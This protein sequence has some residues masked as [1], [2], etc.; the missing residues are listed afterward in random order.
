MQLPSK[1]SSRGAIK[2]NLE[3]N[4]LLSIENTSEN[5]ELIKNLEQNLQIND[6]ILIKHLSAPVALVQVV[7][8]LEQIQFANIYQRKVKVLDWATATMG[9]YPLG[10]NTPKISL[11]SP[12]QSKYIKTWHEQGKQ[13]LINGI[14]LRKLHISQQKMFKNF[15]ID[16][17][18]DNNNT[19]PLVVIAGANGTGKTTLLEYIS[20]NYVLNIGPFYIDNNDYIEIEHNNKI[21]SINN[22]AEKKKKEI[23][24][25]LDEQAKKNGLAGIHFDDSELYYGDLN[26]EVTYIRATDNNDI[27]DVKKNILDFYRKESRELDSYSKT[28]SKVQAF[29]KDIFNGLEVRFTIDDIDDTL[30]DYEEVKL[31]NNMGD[32]FKIENLSSGEKTLL[33]KVLNLYF[34]DIKNQ[35]V[36]VDE[37]ELS[38]HPAWQNRILKLYE[39]FA[40]SNNCQVILATHSP[41]IIAQTPHKNLRFL[42]EEDGKIVTK[43]LTG[44]PLDRDI[45]TIIKTVMG[46]D[47]L[48]KWLEDKHSAYRKL[49]ED[50]K[51]NTEEA[52]KLKREIL[53]FESPNSSFFQGLAFDME[54]M[55]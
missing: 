37:P 23:D 35:I 4:S 34:K 24:D 9:R 15:Q 2:R 43:Q 3:Q 36:L 7:G 41:Q 5:I 30:K 19:L 42:V 28:I 54:L 21:K 32:I 50:G 33:S 31:K 49:C 11:L 52:E 1:A 27:T 16:F 46:A 22:K 29:L 48:P 25:Y 6:L 12:E 8:E 45:N 53:E 39:N 13:K 55:G 26:K 51:K 14:K 40:L 18:D 47:Y 20:G 17:M 44:T 10:G 38:L